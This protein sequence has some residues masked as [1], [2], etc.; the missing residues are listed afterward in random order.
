[1]SSTDLTSRRLS[2]RRLL[3][4][5]AVV[6]VG[7]A[8]A[9][10]IGCSASKPAPAP[11]GG[12]AAPA[13]ASGSTAAARPGVPIVKGTPKDG[14][15]WTIPVYSTSPQHDMHTALNASIWHD[16]SEQA[17]I[18]D[19][20]TG[21]VQANVV[22]KWEIPDNTHFIF[23]VRKGVKLHDVAPWSG[24]EFDAEDLAFNINRIAGNTAES[25]APLT[26]AAFQRADTLAGM[27]KVEAVDKYTVRVTMAKPSSAYLK[28]FLE[29]RNVLMPK[30]IVE[31]GFKDP[32]KFAGVGAYRLTEF[33]PGVRESFAKHP[34]YFRQGEPHFDKV[35]RTVVADSSATL[36]GFISKQFNAIGVDSFQDEQTIKS[37]RPDAVKYSSST[38]QWLYLRPNVKAAMFTD[39][40]VRKAI[41]LAMD[42]QELSEGFYGPGGTLTGPLFSGFSEAW[43]HEK[44][45]TLAGYNQST[46]AKD[47]AEAQKM[48]SAAGR[49]NGDGIAFEVTGGPG[50]GIRQAQKEN[51]VRFQAQ[52][53]KA[54]PGMNITLRTIGDNAQ[55]SALPGSKNFQMITFSSVSQPA[56]A[57]EA[58]S[59]YHSKGGRNYGS[60]EN[61]EAD[62]LL[63]KAL[64]ELDQKALKEI[65]N[66]FQQKCMDEWMPMFGLHVEQKN[67]VVQPNVGGY[68]KV[69]GPWAQGLSSHRIG[70]IYN[71]A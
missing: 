1:M 35:V 63:E 65:L 62:A 52:M 59:L 12:S 30:G 6:G 41:Q 9:A 55:W 70:A 58:Y 36:A 66:T 46:K 4:N 44:L 56:A 29:W 28:G 34:G 10:L 3:G 51:S 60:F 25:E 49:N 18:P 43:D 15:T 54:F 50:T 48:L 17:M 5:G 61:A 19:P 8:G 22:E 13:A 26:K 39:F 45:K 68:D 47:L 20:F 57:S 69:V 42:Y 32:M 38:S 2:R 64:V 37:A 31:V 21:D 27:S 23:H 33:V 40:R 16:I 24:R 14:G 67:T 53:K 71:V 7:L 11:A